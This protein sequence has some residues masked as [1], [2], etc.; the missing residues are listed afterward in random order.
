MVRASSCG[1]RAVLCKCPWTKKEE[2]QGKRGLS[3]PPSLLLSS[4]LPLS[5]SLPSPPSFSLKE[6][7]RENF[8]LPPQGRKKEGS[9]VLSLPGKE[10]KEEGREG[11][12]GRKGKAVLPPTL[13]Q[14]S[15]P[16]PL[17]DP[18]FRCSRGSLLSPPS[19]PHS[20]WR[21]EGELLRR[22]LLRSVRAHHAFAPSAPFPKRVNAGQNNNK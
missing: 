12:E 2:A 3:F 1:R 4:P 13:G 5:P 18:V 19:P 22:P 16:Q 7:G 9:S 6:E 15:P 10:G 11:R 17:G 14:R 20:L 8:F 21:R